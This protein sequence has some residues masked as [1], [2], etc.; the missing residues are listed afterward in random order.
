MKPID[1]DYSNKNLE[2]FDVVYQ[3]IS[4]FSC[5]NTQVKSDFSNLNIRTINLSNNPFTHFFSKFNNEN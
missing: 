5:K 1:L 2:S 3:M 4:D